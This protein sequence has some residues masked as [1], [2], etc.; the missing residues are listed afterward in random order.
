MIYYPKKAKWDPKKTKL[1]TTNIYILICGK[2]II[3]GSF[4]EDKNLSEI[5]R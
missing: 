2:K 4:Y 1:Y 5:I 3:H